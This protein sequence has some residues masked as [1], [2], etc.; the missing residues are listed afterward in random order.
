MLG[1]EAL[2]GMNRTQ[3]AIAEFQA[4][5]KAAP[6]EPNVHF[7]LGY[8]LW[9]QHRYPEAEQEFRL[10]IE[11]EA[12]HAQA[13][14]YLGD[15]EIKLEHAA[16]AEADLRRAVHQ[17]HATQLAWLDLGIVLA[18]EGKNDEAQQDFERAI[19]MDPTG[20]DAHWR[21]ARLYQSTG[22]AD[23]AR[24]E[25]AKARALHENEDKSLI[26][27]LTPGNAASAQPK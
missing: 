7:G 27:Q 4:A 9:K 20:V 6:T 19:A 25:F 22:K 18:G 2:D 13:L 3:D 8:L 26:Q 12:T 11:N 1:G 10:E 16:E 24:A 5:E 23:A 14:A 15:T 17:T 21:L